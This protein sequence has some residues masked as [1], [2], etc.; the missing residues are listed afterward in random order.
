MKHEHD[1]AAGKGGFWI[2]ADGSTIPV[3][4][5]EGHSDTARAVGARHGLS[6]K[7]HDDA[8]ATAYSAGWVRISYC[9]NGVTI[10]TFAGGAAVDALR[11]AVQ[12]CRE[13][14]N[15]RPDVRVDG[16]GD[17]GCPIAAHIRHRL[18]R[19]AEEAGI[20]DFYHRRTA[21]WEERFPHWDSQGHPHL[22]GADVAKL[23]MGHALKV[24][25]RQ[26][27]ASAEAAV[28]KVLETV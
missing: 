7:V 1:Y 16:E 24:N 3:P 18:R 12:I 6:H 19:E 17:Y 4:H 28:E 21:E 5:K 23:L 27:K 10:V 14:I 9:V 22:T 11:S 25:A 20:R 26:R 15:Y 2:K 8:Y 13:Q